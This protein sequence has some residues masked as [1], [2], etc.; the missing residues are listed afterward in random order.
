MYRFFASISLSQA[1]VAAFTA[2]FTLDSGPGVSKIHSPEGRWALAVQTGDPWPWSIASDQGLTVL[3]MGI[4]YMNQAPNES[5][6]RLM[7]ERYRDVGIAGLEGIA[8]HYTYFIADDQT[9]SVHVGSDDAGMLP[10]FYSIHGQTVHL[11]SHPHWI[12]R[13][14][15]EEPELNVS[16]IVD[17][18]RL[19]YSLGNESF[20]KHA[21]RL[22]P[23]ERLRAQDGEVELVRYADPFQ[24]TDEV[25]DLEEAAESV[26]ETFK[27]CLK[28]LIRYWKPAYAHLSGGADSRLILYAMDPADR[29]SMVFHTRAQPA[30]IQT[31]DDAEVNIASRLAGD[32]KLKHIIQVPKGHWMSFLNHEA[33][34]HGPTLT[35]IHGGELLGGMAF[36]FTPT[37]LEELE[38]KSLKPID[39]IDA[40]E[41]RDP[42]S[43]LSKLPAFGSEW[44]ERAFLYRQFLR[45]FR[46]SIYMNATGGWTSPYHFG[47]YSVGPFWDARFLRALI[48]VPN[49]L[50]TNYWLYGELLRR[51][52]G[53]L[54]VEFNS[55]IV[56]FVHGCRS[57]APGKDPKSVFDADPM[58]SVR[59]IDMDVF[60]RVSGLYHREPLKTAAARYGGEMGLRLN[61][62]QRF[63]SSLNEGGFS[64]GY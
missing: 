23:G 10:L 20:L 62:L 18:L 32:L 14:R 30:L 44:S 45:A 49:D 6:A 7:L 33:P 35:G 5:P 63:T 39:F 54:D 3:V 12:L 43:T 50:I 64:L 11:A 42:S 40:P 28:D 52:P 22:A 9:Q 15:R 29:A 1:P 4:P 27:L 2:D 17:F 21:G 58:A 25:L 55:Q 8:G 59:D 60:D 16:S 13:A 57:G 48:R 19:G 46:S 53:A 26:L 56:N 38:T 61:N 37:K 41:A 36:K 31:G 47:F 51:L 34:V 24:E